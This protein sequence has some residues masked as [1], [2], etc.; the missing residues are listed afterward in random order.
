MR[1]IRSTLQPI[2]MTQ[3]CCDTV[4]KHNDLGKINTTRIQ[5]DS[6]VLTI[7][8]IAMYSYK[9]DPIT[10]ACFAVIV[11]HSVAG[12]SSTS[13][14][15]QLLFGLML[16]DHSYGGAL[17][18]IEAALDEIKDLL[19]GYRLNYDLVNIQVSYLRTILIMHGC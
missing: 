6:L 14:D 4:R 3:L 2:I 16:G 19:P 8:N 12:V 7:F 10:Y 11:V 5:S 9:M 17:S 1:N 15:R 18:G 13:A